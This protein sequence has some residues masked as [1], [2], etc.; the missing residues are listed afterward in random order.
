MVNKAIFFVLLLVFSVSGY[1]AAQSENA[2]P[3]LWIQSSDLP[4]LQAWAVPT[5]P[6]YQDG[7]LAMAQRATADM[8][9]GIIP[10]QDTGSIAYEEY[11][12]ESYAL[13]F[14]FMSLIVT[15]DNVRQEYAQRARTLLM[16]VMNE[17]VKGVDESQPFRHPEFS[18]SDRSR[19]QGISFGLTVDWIYPILTAED[20]A[21]IRTVF[22]RWCEENINAYTTNFNRPEPIGVVNDPILIADR[23]AV[24]WAGNNYYSAHMRNIGIMA[25]ALDA[26]DDLDGALHAY[27]ENATG[28]WLYVIDHLLRT[29]AAGGFGTEGFEYSP[30]SVGYVAEFL[31][32]LYTAGVTDTTQWGQQ[33]SIENN[34]FW[35]D[36]II[37]FVS[38]LSPVPAANPDYGTVYLPAWYGSGQD[39]RAPDMVELFAPLAIYAQLQ[40]DVQT[41]DALRWVQ[42]HTPPGGAAGLLDRVTSVDSMNK[43]ILYF[44]LYDPQV[45]TF[46][47]PRPTYPTAWYAPGMRR[48]LARTDW[49][50]TAA[51]LSYNL[52]WDTVDHQ[53]GNG[54]A[55]EFYRAGEW[56]TKIR[57]GY[58]FD[59]HTSDNMNTLTV[60]N[61]LPDRD[62]YRLMI[63][64]R[65]SQWLYSAGDPLPP[66]FAIN[67]DYIVVYG[68]ATPLYNSEYE[69]VTD[70]E[71]VSRSLVWLK[72]DIVVIYDRAATA[73][74]NPVMRFWLNFP[75]N[76]TVSDTLTT[77]TTLAGQHLY[78]NTLLPLNAA[79]SVTPLADEAS[80]PPAHYENMRYRLMVEPSNPVSETRFLHVLQGADAGTMPLATTLFE[81]TGGTAYQGV[82]VGD[83]ALL[84]PV[85]STTAFDSVTYSANA[86][87]HLITG[88]IPNAAYDVAMTGTG[89]SLQITITPGSTYVADMGGTVLI[90]PT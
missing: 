83:T 68:D 38:S 71:H 49:S 10:A 79:I 12:T 76:A 27:L 74:A 88:L 51:L 73:A 1:S 9:A 82:I 41:L 25:L 32:A 26:A 35:H 5:N 46:T 65:G 81:S 69:G 44:L 23:V 42:L 36:S 56:L 17:A 85:D 18:T 40:G 72:P 29:D 22:L 2:H 45:T 3:H 6:L 24:R 43:A 19:W 59:Y 50:E 34:P 75:D 58:D 84:F 31:L 52:S 16:H 63:A 87:R 7:L 54:N 37:A 39:Y 15:E 48:L 78:V 11:P 13:L 30:Q 62:D 70:V 66:I 77:M 28:A 57:V 86:A 47:D 20:K 67:T 8:D 53:S 33:I 89:A 14:A 4:R 21:T 61:T 55:I 60:M 80:S 64:Q 90:N